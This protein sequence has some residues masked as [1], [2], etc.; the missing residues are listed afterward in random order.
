MLHPP[1]VNTLFYGDNLHILR[2]FVANETVDLVYLDPPFNSN[3]TC[4]VLFKAP[5]G[6]GSPAQIE[7]F[8]DTWHRNEAAERAF[9]EVLKSGISAAAE[10]LRAMR[11]FLKETD[12][13]ERAPKSAP[14]DRGASGRPRR[15]TA[16]ASR[17][18]GR[19]P[20]FC[21]EPPAERRRRG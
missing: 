14:R 12:R 7:A 6:E 2:E 11:S 21:P 17:A 9:D 4:N 19:K 16:S 10:M 13:P 5:T 3:A 8:E 15:V 20:E 1:A 18:G